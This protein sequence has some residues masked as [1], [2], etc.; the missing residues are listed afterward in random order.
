MAAGNVGGAAERAAVERYADDDD[1]LLREHAE[2]ALAP[3]R[4]AEPDAERVKLIRILCVVRRGARAPALAK[5]LLDR[6]E[7]PAGLRGRRLV[8]ARRAGARRRSRLLVLALRWRG[9]LRRL[10][11]LNVAADFALVGAL[12]LV[13]AWDPGQ[14][15]R[16]LPYLV[17]LEAALFFRLRGGL[18]VAALDGAALRGR[19]GVA[20]IRVRRPGSRSTRSCSAG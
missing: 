16:T 20:R 6:G 3:D 12:L 7:L 2:W 4:R 1:P 17:V 11:M 9:R 14:P 15:L 19:G 18:I 5:L 8:A 13:Y 10:A